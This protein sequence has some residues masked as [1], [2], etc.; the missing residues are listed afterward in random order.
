MLIS[1]NYGEMET[2]KLVYNNKTLKNKEAKLRD[3]IP[4]VE[5]KDE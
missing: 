3:V 1:L 4:Y 2:C 5:K